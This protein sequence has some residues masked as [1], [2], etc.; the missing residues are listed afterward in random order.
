MHSYRMPSMI[1]LAMLV[2]VGTPQPSAQVPDWE[3]LR[4]W[5]AY[6]ARRPLEVIEKSVDVR[7]QAR[8]YDLTY[9][10][11]KGGPVPAYL[12]LPAG[13]GPIDAAVLFLHPG[14]GDRAT[15]VPEGVTLAEFGVAS[16][17]IDAPHLRPVPWRSGFVDTE[18]PVH[19]RD[20]MIQTV[21]DLRRGIELLHPRLRRQPDVR[22]QRD[23][24]SGRARVR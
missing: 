4:G 11:P 15:F 14:Q 5:F 9:A 24:L 7:G 17:S 16:L 10:S 2:A 22:R 13:D 6:E 19:S 8:V 23:R 18:D 20:S 3:H 1:L 21:V 12:I